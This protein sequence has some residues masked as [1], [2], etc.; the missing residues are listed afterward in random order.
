[1]SADEFIKKH[2]ENEITKMMKADLQDANLV[3]SSMIRDDS[4]EMPESA[5]RMD[6]LKPMTD[7]NVMRNTHAS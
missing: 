1:M 4:M 7:L 6:K 5:S 3:D 2:G